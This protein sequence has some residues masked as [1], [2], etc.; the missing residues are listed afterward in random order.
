[1][2]KFFEMFMCGM[3]YFWIANQ[4]SPYAFNKHFRTILGGVKSKAIKGES[5]RNNKLTYSSVM[6][7]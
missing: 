3:D 7:K 1:V 6:N 4:F 5:G 2:E